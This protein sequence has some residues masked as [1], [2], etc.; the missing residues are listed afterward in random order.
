MRWAEW[1]KLLRKDFR[2]AKFKNLPTNIRKPWSAESKKSSASIN[3]RWPTNY[4]K[5]QFSLLMR[6]FA[7]TR[8]KDSSEPEH[9]E[10]TLR[11][12]E[13]LM[14]S[15]KLRSVATIRCQRRLTRCE[16]TRPSAKSVQRCE[17]FT[18]STK[19]RPFNAAWITQP[20]R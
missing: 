20:E 12:K 11:S 16:N 10:T 13:R 15:G 18:A 1:S 8:L 17:T 19:S 5:F 2:N 3:M 7:V 4:R 6:V 14:R 9:N